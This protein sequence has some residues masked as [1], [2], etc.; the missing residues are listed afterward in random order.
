MPKRSEKQ[1]QGFSIKLTK[2][3]MKLLKTMRKK[4]IEKEEREEFEE[5]IGIK[6]ERENETGSKEYLVVWVDKTESWVRLLD[7]KC[8][9]IME[10]YL[11][12]KHG[13]Q[14]FRE[15]ANGPYRPTH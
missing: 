15:M 5:V 7:M 14:L 13:Y 4:R 12:V 8:P 6:K 3:E 2:E 9:A 11:L 1:K 10:K